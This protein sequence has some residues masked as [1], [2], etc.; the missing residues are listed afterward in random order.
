MA[1]WVKSEYANEL[2]VLSAWLAALL[3]WNVTYT[4]EVLGGNLLYVRFPFFQ[5]RYNFGVAIGRAIRFDTPLSAARFQEGQSLALPYQ[6]WAAGAAVLAVA[7]LLSVVFYLQE[8]R[9]EAS[10]VDPVRLMGG[11]LGLGTLVLGVSTYY[12]YTQGFPGIKVPVGLALLGVLAAML[13]TVDRSDRGV[14]EPAADA[15]ADPEGT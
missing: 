2:A 5:V 10:P 9:L 11:V 14:A 6:V 1:P 3:P 12:L 4:S 8:D 13:L 7:V 15:E